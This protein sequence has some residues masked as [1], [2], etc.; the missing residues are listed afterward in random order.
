MVLGVLKHIL[1]VV[2]VMG[3]IF[4]SFVWAGDGVYLQRFDLVLKRLAAL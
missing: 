4:P 2:F 1:A 3:V